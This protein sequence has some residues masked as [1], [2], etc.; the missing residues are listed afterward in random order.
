[1]AQAK[2]LTKQELKRLLDVTRGGSRYVEKDITMLLLTYWCGLRVGEVV[3]L[4]ISDVVDERGAARAETVTCSAH[5]RIH[6]PQPT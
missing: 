1:M 4:R 3:A 6:T 5:R 2:T